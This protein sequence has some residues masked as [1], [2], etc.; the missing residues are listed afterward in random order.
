[1]VAFAIQDIAHTFRP[2]HRVMVQVQSTWFPLVDRNPQQFVDIYKAKASDFLKATHRLYH[3]PQRPS[4][5][6]I[7][8]T[9]LPHS[10]PTGSHES[11]DRQ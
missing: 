8:V 3:S 1:M 7:L 11:G 10:A 5:L 6:K 2:G 9:A 4:R